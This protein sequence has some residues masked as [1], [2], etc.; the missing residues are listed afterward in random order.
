MKTNM[1]II[2]QPLSIRCMAAS[3][4]VDILKNTH[5]SERICRPGHKCLGI[6][7]KWCCVNMVPNHYAT[8]SIFAPL[9]SFRCQFYTWEWKR[10]NAVDCVG[11]NRKRVQQGPG[12]PLLPESK[13]STSYSGS[14]TIPEFWHEYLKKRCVHIIAQLVPYTGKKTATKCEHRLNQ[15]FV[16][17]TLS[18]SFPARLSF[19]IF[20]SFVFK[21][22]PR[23]AILLWD[24]SSST[25]FDKAFNTKVKSKKYS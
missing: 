12:A 18:S 9:H 4:T 13:V 19:L 20:P 23:L 15:N 22:L 14:R 11:I 21:L 25:R 3:F 10:V 24:K 16:P 7:T 2:L 6:G 17:C 5:Y 1:K 8:V